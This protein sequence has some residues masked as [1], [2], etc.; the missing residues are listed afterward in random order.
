[1][2]DITR[3]DAIRA[4]V[5]ATALGSLATAVEACGGGG[6]GTSSSPAPISSAPDG[7]A[8]KTITSASKVPVGG[9]T[10]LAGDHVVVTQPKQGVFNAFSSTC[11]HQGCTVGQVSGGLIKC[12]CHGSEF[13]I[14]DGTVAHGPAQRPLPRYRVALKGDAVTLA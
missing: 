11:T 6:S 5:G 12:P 1:M 8:G 10:I 9:G 13:H 2:P 14:K 7:L 3:R 4:M